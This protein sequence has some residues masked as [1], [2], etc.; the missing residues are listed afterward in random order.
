MLTMLNEV[1]SGQLSSNRSVA[2]VGS[3]E[4]VKDGLQALMD[5][6]YPGKVVI[7]PHIKPFPLTS[8]PDLEKTLPNVFAKLKN[9]REWTQEAE[10]E[11]LETLLE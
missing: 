7:F 1:E 4:A 5:S 3:L 9:G 10:R 11:F 6:T 2:A 8:L